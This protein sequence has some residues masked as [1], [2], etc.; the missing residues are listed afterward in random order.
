MSFS[1]WLIGRFPDEVRKVVR[2]HA[3]VRR[4]ERR[5]F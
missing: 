5:L 4:S 3:P 1:K 2:I